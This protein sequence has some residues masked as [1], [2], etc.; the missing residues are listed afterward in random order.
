MASRKR[1]QAE[2]LATA[3]DLDDEIVFDGSLGEERSW[4]TH[5]DGVAEISL[6]ITWSTLLPQ[7]DEDSD[8]SVHFNGAEG[9]LPLEETI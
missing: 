3:L 8:G 5:M 6:D 2:T 7:R 9:E 1:R 4:D